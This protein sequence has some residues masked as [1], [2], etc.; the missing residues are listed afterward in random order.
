MPE[1][2]LPEARRVL[3]GAFYGAYSSLTILLV[4]CVMNIAVV[5]ILYSRVSTGPSLLSGRCKCFVSVSILVWYF[6]TVF[7]WYCTVWEAM[8]GGNVQCVW[9]CH[10]R[11]C[12]Q[13]DT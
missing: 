12:S 7:M 4:H 2:H 1:D 11:S 5:L 8:G 10:W 9:C 3:K 13:I 6:Q